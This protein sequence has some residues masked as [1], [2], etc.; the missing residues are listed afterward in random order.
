M[1]STLNKYLAERL[2][3]GG[4][5]QSIIA[6]IEVSAGFVSSSEISLGDYFSFQLWAT[7]GN[8]I[9]GTVFVAAIKYGQLGDRTFV[10][11]GQ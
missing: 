2:W 1:P 10:S 9:G 7:A 8:I 5:H 11:R 3:F 4:L 6:S